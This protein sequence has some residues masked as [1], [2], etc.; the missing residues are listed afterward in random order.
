[1]IIV[2]Y[3]VLQI[4]KSLRV[5]VAKCHPNILEINDNGLF[6]I[7]SEFLKLSFHN[8]HYNLTINDIPIKIDKDNIKEYWI[9]PNK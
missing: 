1:M 3:V 8:E 2:M 7:E 5:E 9:N 6:R 4:I